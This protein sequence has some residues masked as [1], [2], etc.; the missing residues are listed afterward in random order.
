MPLRV[1]KLE[2]GHAPR[3]RRQRLWAFSRDRFPARLCGQ[4]GVGGRHV[5][6]NDGEVLKQIAPR[7]NIGG[8]GLAFRVNAEELNRLAAQLQRNK[9]RLRAGNAKERLKRSPGQ[10]R[11]IASHES[12]SVLV[13]CGHVQQVPSAQN[14]PPQPVSVEFRPFGTI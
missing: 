5:G 13:K 10:L 6:N 4:F 12:K 2:R 3:R 11:V 9:S 14:C 8:V 1:L 7:R